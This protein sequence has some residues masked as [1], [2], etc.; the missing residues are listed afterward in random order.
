MAKVVIMINGE[1]VDFNQIE[2]LVTK[3][4]ELEQ[5][6]QELK[7]A[8]DNLVGQLHGEGCRYNILDE[9][10]SDLQ[11]EYDEL[12]DILIEKNEAINQAFKILEQFQTIS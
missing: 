7:E 1:A 10:F 4:K 6:N 5:E 2:V 9:A 11:S 8:N 12:E 3:I